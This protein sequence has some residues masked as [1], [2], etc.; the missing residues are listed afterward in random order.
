M[1]SEKEKMLTGELDRASDPVL[2]Q[3]HL[4]AQAL[5]AE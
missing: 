4:A 3:E 5:T 2:V 1:K